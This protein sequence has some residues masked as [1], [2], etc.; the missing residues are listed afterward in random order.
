M[1]EPIVYLLFQRLILLSM[2]G[3]LR[4]EKI[5]TESILSRKL[6]LKLFFNI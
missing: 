4:S 5:T 3:K 2:V 1:Y 6:T